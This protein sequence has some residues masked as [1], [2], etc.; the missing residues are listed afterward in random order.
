MPDPNFSSNHGP[1]QE[2]RKIRLR[3]YC[4]A[5][6]FHYRR[7]RRRRGERLVGRR[8]STLRQVT[9]LFLYAG[10]A[11]ATIRSGLRRCVV[12]LVTR[13]ESRAK[14][15]TRARLAPVDY[16]PFEIIQHLASDDE[17]A[18]A[19]TCW[20]S[21]RLRTQRPRGDCKHERQIIYCHFG[22]NEPPGSRHRRDR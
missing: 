21:S 22:P 11:S 20:H 3:A 5:A 15:R 1:R 19:G 16:A 8:V 4:A 7:T 2:R 14:G 12:F 17:I 13:V 6:K 9:D 10:I 18:V